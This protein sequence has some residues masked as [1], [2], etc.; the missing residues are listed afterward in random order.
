[1]GLGKTEITFSLIF[2]YI[3]IILFYGFYGG[4]VQKDDLS[5]KEINNKTLGI[6]F[7]IVEGINSLPVEVNTAIFSGLAIFTGFVIITSLPT[8]S[9]S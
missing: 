4:E 1:M 2:F 3:F 9:V 8:F 5:V 6:Q 7:N